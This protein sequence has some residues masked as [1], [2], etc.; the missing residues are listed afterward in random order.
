M[1]IVTG[2]Y[3]M[4]AVAVISAGALTGLVAWLSLNGSKDR[5][6]HG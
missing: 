4:C 6:R 3:V 2:I 5:R 1:S